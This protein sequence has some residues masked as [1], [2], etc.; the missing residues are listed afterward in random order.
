MHSHDRTMLAKLG[1]ADPD[2]RNPRHDMAIQ[3]L[4]QPAM[5]SKLTKASPKASPK[6]F[7]TCLEFHITKGYGQYM[8]TVGF[9]DI[10][11]RFRFSGCNTGLRALSPEIEADLH[12]RHKQLR[13]GLSLLIEKRHRLKE[14]KI[15]L[16]KHPDAERLLNDYAKCLGSRKR[17]I[18]HQKYVFMRQLDGVLLIEVK[19]TPVSAGDVLRQMRLY[20]EYLNCSHH[21]S[22]YD[23]PEKDRRMFYH[24]TVYR[25]DIL[26]IHPVVVTD[27]EI[28]EGDAR[29]FADE[30]IAHYRLGSGFESFV[31]A[32]KNAISVE[33]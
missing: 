24:E 2:K 18:A 6:A 14:G 28:S 9:A 27:Y 32:R 21:G 15:D 17:A 12:K 4:S 7:E 5:L 26:K 23:L 16:V 30:Q 13:D 29:V 8:T 22:I 20:L 25:T 19:I 11:S 31:A 1:F 10:V 3:Y 33:I